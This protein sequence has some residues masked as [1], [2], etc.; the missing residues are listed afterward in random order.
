MILPTFTVVA[1]ADLDG[2]PTGTDITDQLCGA[3]CEVRLNE[4]GDGGVLVPHGETITPDPVGKA[5]VIAFDGD[6]AATIIIEGRRDV[7]VDPGE[8]SRMVTEYYG[9][10]IGSLLD[11]YRCRPTFGPE[12]QPW[13]LTRTFS[14]ASPEYDASSWGTATEYGTLLDSTDFWDGKPA[15]FP[16]FTTE[17][18]G[19]SEGDDNSAPEGY[20]WWLEDF[21][22]DEDSTL[23]FFTASDNSQD[24]YFG[25]FQLGRVAS[26]GIDTKSFTQAT[27]YDF[28]SSAGT[29]RVAGKVVNI[30]FGGGDPGYGEGS[31]VAG[32]PSFTIGAIYKVGADGRLGEL[33]WESSSTTKLLSYPDDPPGL[34][35]AEVVDILVAEAIADGVDPEF[36]VV[37]NGSWDPV[38]NITL[39][40]GQSLL[41]HLRDRADGSWLDWSVSPIDTELQL[42]PSGGRGGASGVTYSTANADLIRLQATMLDVDVSGL[43]VAYVGGWTFVGTAEKP[44]SLRTRAA[45]IGEA[46]ALAQAIL[47]RDP[48]PEQVTVDV[49]PSTGK[50]PGVDVL[51]GDTVTCGSFTTEKLIGWSMAWSADSTEEP[52]FDLTLKDRIRGDEERL[53]LMVARAAPGQLG[54]TAPA[55]PAQDPPEFNTDINPSELTFQYDAGAPVLSP[56]KRASQS[57]NLYAVAVTST[58]AGSTDSDFEYLVDGV[59]ILGGAGTL[60]SGETFTII[61][62]DPIVWVTANVSALQGNI[63]SLGTGVDTLLIEPRFV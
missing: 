44:A 38:E 5:I 53:A 61:P 29:R 36:T 50:I 63:V 33:V 14:F 49:K 59:D 51:D 20:W 54:G 62:V 2:T 6:V 22:L 26:D 52:K 35:D 9:R 40:V 11:R 58:P 27:R 60:P 31:E 57:G 43:W 12:R 42:W 37:T 32:N 24:V 19:P 56:E 23:A 4:E 13:A 48:Q 1:L 45:T 55:S 8:E 21:T 10:G 41:E 25:G 47:D 7:E 16:S 18:I 15:G 30:P 3:D 34:T 46:K 28:F 17:R 39:D